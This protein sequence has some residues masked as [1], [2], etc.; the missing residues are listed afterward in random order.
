MIA[1]YLFY[2][3]YYYIYVNTFLFNRKV[4]KAKY[5]RNSH[6]FIVKYEIRGVKN[7]ELRG[8]PGFI[9]LTS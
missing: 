4:E 9:C 1:R 5:D 8:L 2:Y 3:K 7:S 6:N